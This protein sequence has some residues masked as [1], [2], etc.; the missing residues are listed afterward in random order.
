V[1]EALVRAWRGYAGV[2]ERGAMKSWLYRIVRNEFLR[3][4]GAERPA[5]DLED[6]DMP[7]ADER[8][9]LHGLEMRDA[10]GALPTVYAEPLALQVLGGF[11]GAE[12]AALMG[13]TQGAVM[14]RLTRARQALRRLV[15]PEPRA[16]RRREG[17]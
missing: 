14:T 11:S 7:A 2:R 12:I 4:R 16:G 17:L 8:S 6:F 9:G 10:I 15:Q 3:A 13:T 1:Q 5:A